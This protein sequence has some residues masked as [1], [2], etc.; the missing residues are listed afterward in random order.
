M[1]HLPN[2]SYLHLPGVNHP[3]DGHEHEAAPGPVSAV[4]CAIL[5]HLFMQPFHAWPLPTMNG[6]EKYFFL[7]SPA[8]SIQLSMPFFLIRQRL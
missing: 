2:Q 8:S 5:H 7:I 1:I 6:S 4:L 3:L